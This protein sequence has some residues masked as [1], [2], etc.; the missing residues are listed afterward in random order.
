MRHGAE[1]A[2]RVGGHAA[3]ARL[4]ADEARERRRDPDGASPVGAEMEDAGPRG[5]RG[6]GTA[7]RPAWRHVGVP[8]ITCDP[9]ERAVRQRLPAEFGR[10]REPQDG[11]AGRPEAGDRRRVRRA[12]DLAGA[13]AAVA[14]RPSFDPDDVLD[15]GRDAVDRGL[16]STVAPP[17]FRLARR[18][19]W[20]RADR[21]A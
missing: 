2:R 17:R 5:S 9:A 7:R 6:R 4:Q 16:R 3:I 10:G 20:Q 8:G 19:P 1:R 14:D 15:R 21:C 18:R 13:R 12:G 11:D